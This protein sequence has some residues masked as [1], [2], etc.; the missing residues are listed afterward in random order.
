MAKAKKS[1]SR[2]DYSKEVE[3]IRRLQDLNK[4]LKAGDVEN[5]LLSNSAKDSET[6]PDN[7]LDSLL[8][9]A[10]AEEQG[11]GKGLEVI[12]RLTIGT[13]GY[14]VTKETSVKVKKSKGKTRLVRTVR[15][16]KKMPK[17]KKRGR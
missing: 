8:E 12:E 11:G 13:G 16:S 7:V 17:A 6:L 14:R 1:R 3:E 5:A 15:A 9:K 4:I 10:N 2:A